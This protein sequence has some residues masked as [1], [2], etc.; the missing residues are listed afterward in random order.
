MLNELF[1]L[2]SCKLRIESISVVIVDN[3]LFWF[4]IFLFFF[5]SI[6]RCYWI[7][8]NFKKKKNR[9]QS[10]DIGTQWDDVKRWSL[11]NVN[12]TTTVWIKNGMNIRWRHC[13]Q[14][15]ANENM[16]MLLCVCGVCVLVVFVFF[17]IHRFSIHR[18]IVCRRW[19]RVSAC[20]PSDKRMKQFLS[21]HLQPN[22]T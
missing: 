8:E 22:Q 19:Y 2:S 1:N 18:W 15:P 13:M 7:E 10:I 6:H 17:F 16:Y 21:L 11:S 20:M 3:M 14:L 12:S 5:I 4:F 9:H